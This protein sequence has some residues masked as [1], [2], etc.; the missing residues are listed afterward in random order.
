LHH[1]LHHPERPFAGLVL[2]APP[3]RSVGAVAHT[4]IAAQ[5]AQLPDAEALLRA[6]D[7]SIAR[8]VAGEPVAPD[9][10]LP[11]GVKLLLQSL[12]APANLPFARELWT[13][14]A[15]SLL[16]RV[17]APVLVLIGK[18][19]VQVDWRVDGEPLERAAAGRNEVTFHYPEHAN[20]VLKFEPRP[21]ADL[22]GANVLQSY[23]G[24]DARL[25]PESLAII[26][27]WLRAR[28]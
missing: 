20:H 15:A 22:S 10:S 26:T 25:D 8:F 2:T 28:L 9:P 5:A 3:G 17:S 19:D 6:Y 27:E 11:Q 16:H 23:N 12:E 4:Q 21:R 1:Q 24:P 13:A 14:D 18:K 7:E